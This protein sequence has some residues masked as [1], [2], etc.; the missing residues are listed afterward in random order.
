MT[1]PNLITPRLILRPFAL[2]DAPRVARLCADRRIA[3]TTLHIP[4]PYT[5][6]DAE[7][8][9]ASLPASATAG[10]GFVFAL[11][12]PTAAGVPGDVIGAMGLQINLKYN[13]AELGYW[14]APDQWSKGYT[15]EAAHAVI[16]FGFESL[17][18]IRIHAHHFHTNP[19]SGRVMQKVGMSF[20]GILRKHVI[21][22]GQAL[23]SICYGVLADEWP[24][25][26]ETHQ[27]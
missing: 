7:S 24:P 6:A 5:L 10:T 8:W 13:H 21:K 4:H 2:G 25:A 14:L 1:P 27:N 23:D 12:L 20:E 17:K 9:L 18:L 22:W 3:E 26:A 16:T 15:T 11:T 19:A